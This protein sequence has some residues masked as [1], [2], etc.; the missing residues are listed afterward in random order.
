MTIC[1]K[2]RIILLLLIFFLFTNITQAATSSDW[3]K[4]TIYQV[5]T[6]RFALANNV[7]RKTCTNLSGYCGGTWRGIQDHLDY[8]QGLGFN[9]IWISPIVSNSDGGYHG[10]WLKDL[11]QVNAHFGTEKDLKNLVKECHKR[12]IFVMVDIVFN[13]VAP[14]GM[15]FKQISPFNQSEH[16]HPYCEVV[17]FLNQTQV[18]LCRLL[19]L[20]DLDQQ[21]P[22][23]FKQL[24]NWL[25][26]IINFYEFDGIRL[27]TVPYISQNF[28]KSI[29]SDVVVP[30]CQ[31]IYMVGEVFDPRIDYAAGYANIIG[32]TLNYPLYFTLKRTY[33]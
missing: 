30:K 5:L 4:R 8:I 2:N 18:E 17:D 10:Y 6:D 24:S 20:P 19:N 25:E 27:D 16:Y 9:A 7:S 32:G 31:N 28:W 29:V 21:N 1:T 13:H 33:I 23:V 3:K 15:D 11:W 22:F 14:V 26:F 12:D